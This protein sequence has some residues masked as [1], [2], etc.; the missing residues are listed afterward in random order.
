MI[1]VNEGIHHDAEPSAHPV[2]YLLPATDLEEGMSTDDG[3]DIV[4]VSRSDEW[5]FVDVYT[6]RSDDPELDAENR[7]ETDCRMYRPNELVG[8]ATF[9]DTAIDAS[10]ADTAQPHPLAPRVHHATSDDNEQQRPEG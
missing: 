2:F 6:P 9:D 4:D 3:Q 10:D 5:V 1:P 7:H 8:M